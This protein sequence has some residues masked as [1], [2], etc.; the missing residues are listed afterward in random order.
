MAAMTVAI[1]GLLTVSLILVRNRRVLFRAK[2]SS[3]AK[4][5]LLHSSGS[6][7]GIR[8]DW[9]IP[10]SELHFE[11]RIGVGSYGEVFKAKWHGARVAV[12]QL[13]THSST[14]IEQLFATEV[15]I[16]SRLRH[17]N[18]VMLLGACTPPPA[19]CIVTEYVSRGNLA[20]MLHDTAVDITWQRML[21]FAADAARGMAHLH[22]LGI[23]HRD[24]K[25]GNLL[26]DDQWGVK[27]A[28]FGLSR[29]SLPGTMTHCG[30]PQYAAP[31]V[32]R[33]E[34]YGPAAD[35]FSFGMVLWELI[36][37]RAAYAGHHQLALGMAVAFKGL[38]PPIPVGCPTTLTQLMTA[39]W[40]V[41]PQQRPTFPEILDTL[42]VMPT[43]SHPQLPLS[44]PDIVI[45]MPGPDAAS[46]PIQPP[47]QP[48]AYQASP[49][50]PAAAAGTRTSTS[51]AA[52]A[53]QSIEDDPA[54][55]ASTASLSSAYNSR[56]S[57]HS[58]RS[59]LLPNEQ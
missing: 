59:P 41:D 52:L 18:V 5:G 45:D 27:I 26:V 8:S 22:A 14:Q 9:K 10:F 3:N 23:L 58:K 31:E 28:D 48:L 19:Y 56:T 1:V 43:P 46:Q 49:G 40:H 2:L 51:A 37:R 12:K 38:R 33:S 57:R 30:T 17:P 7:S 35:V 34:H 13:Y 54:F 39:C 44:A 11:Q 50:G 21:R 53:Q 20:D 24:L 36:T 4:A 29:S 47:L 42:S 6:G 32:L 25:N 16:M 15:G 55:S